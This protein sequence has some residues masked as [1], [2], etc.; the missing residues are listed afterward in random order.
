MSSPARPHLAAQRVVIVDGARGG[1]P[2]RPVPHVTAALAPAGT[3]RIGVYPGSPTSLIRDP[4]TG[5]ARGLTVDLGR[6]LAGRLGVPWTLVEFPRA[7]EVLEALKADRVDVTVTNVTP[8]RAADVD[9]S[10]PLLAIELSCLVRPD[11]P[12]R[13]VADVDQ[14][15]LRVG[16]SQGSTSQATLGR[17]LRHATVVPAPTLAAAVDMLGAGGIDA[18]ATNKAILYAMADRQPG[19]RVLDGAWGKEEIALAIPRGRG[20][21]IAYVRAFAEEARGEGLARRAAERAGL[22]GTVAD[23]TR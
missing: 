14:P 13:T 23:G 6:E 9:F 3:L 22:R 19:S 15:G 18:F 5:K 10:A 11:S 7:A 20:D 4:A 1:P 2:A 8:T 12:L 21:A 16:V 17:T